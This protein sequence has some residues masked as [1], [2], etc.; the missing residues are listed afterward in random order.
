MSRPSIENLWS[1][2]WTARFGFEDVR[3]RFELGGEEF[4]NTT[5]SVPRFLQAHRRASTVA[6]AMFRESCIGIVAWNG[7]LPNQAGLADE[8]ADGF[9]ALHST[10]F[11]APLIS[12]WQAVLYTDP[13][14]EA[15]VWDIRSYDMGLDKMARDTLLWHAVASEMPIYPRA[16][17]V[18]FLIDPN[19]SVMMHI[20]DDRGMDVSAFDAAKLKGLYAGFADWL[21]DYD[22]ERMA[23]LF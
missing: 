6:D 23:K 1:S 5:E 8:V 12:E 17:V 20:Y 9:M 3:L 18:T 19:A 15:D 16:P 2:L 13:G 7:R 21:L 11:H 22:L 10:G 14:E 4:D